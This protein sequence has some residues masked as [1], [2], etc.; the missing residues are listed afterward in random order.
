MARHDPAVELR[1][2]SQ[3]RALA[4]D[5]KRAESERPHFRL[6]V[7]RGRLGVELDGVFALG[8]VVVQQLSATF[9][10]IR[11]PVELTGGVDAFR[12][13]RGQLESVRLALDAAAIAKLPAT[14]L[15]GILDGKTPN[16]ICAALEDGFLVGVSSG[17][18]ALAFE[19][20]VAPL[21][22][23]V[24][25]IPTAARGLGLGGPPQVYAGRVLQALLKPLGRAVGGAVVLENLAGDIAKHVF[26]RAGM[27]APA[28][29]L[30]C[31]APPDLQ[32]TQLRLQ[33]L[34]EGETGASSERVLSGI[35]LATLVAEAEAAM[36]ASDMD[37]ARR[38][39]LSALEQAP[40]HPEIARRLAE[41]DRAAGERAEAALGSLSEAMTPMEAGIIGGVLLAE[42]GDEHGAG[43]ALRRAAE[44]EPYGA[45]ASAVWLE[46]ARVATVSTEVEAPLDEA[47][48]RAP[49]S[50]IARWA[51]FEYR[52]THG[53]TEGASE[54][55]E[56]LE[57]AAGSP[58]ERHSVLRRAATRFLDARH[59]DQAAKLFER[60]LRYAPDSVDGVAGLARALQ[61]L[62]KR[63][64]A[65]ALL[66]RAVGLAERADRPAHRVTVDLARALVDVADDRPAAIA[67]VRRVPP[68]VA[69]TFEA[70]LLDARWRVQ[71]GDMAGASVALGQLGDAVEH[72][73][74]LLTDGPES[75]DTAFVSLW[76][77]E[78]ASATR[79]DAQR[80]VARLLEEG[81]RIEELDR[82]DTRAARRL[83]SLALRLDPKSHALGKA[84][85]R[86]HAEVTPPKVAGPTGMETSSQ[87]PTEGTL[88]SPASDVDP[89]QFDASRGFMPTGDSTQESVVSEELLALKPGIV[90]AEMDEPPAGSAPADGSGDEPAPDG[91]SGAVAKLGDDPFGLAGLDE[92]VSEDEI[93]V[94][95][96]SEKLRADPSNVEIVRQLAGALERLE[97][98]MELFAL[99]SARIEE[100]DEQLKAELNPLRRDAL[101]RLAARATAEGRDGEAE[102]YRSMLAQDEGPQGD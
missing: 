45:L 34:R 23:D 62:G 68:W 53:K 84:F 82:G 13:K 55:V 60:A 27:R 70:R 90:S 25:F 11:F 37:G 32:L 41:L 89:G 102:L 3:A 52:L 42:V 44:A 31:W 19:V 96:L 97:R 33:A 100:G 91:V 73:L 35:E 8:P 17:S 51:R 49:G 7:T 59:L 79:A 67:H 63:K 83:L 26:P 14:R 88:Q 74:G 61:T 18:Q 4:D 92:D 86:V 43:V 16:F 81:A 1:I 38:A 58:H 66:S 30:M 57:A 56:H 76:G 95:Q 64:R 77:P 80:S 78:H 47:V 87:S 94:D 10:G 12:S 39:Y 72:A 65:L 29:S 54:D 22:G 46:L 50:G 101:E 40:R 6:V 9:S 2:S 71:L 21:D 15:R 24:R 69:E 36:L 75:S 98:D 99:L 93:L 48:A 85:A 5:A 20:L 28:T